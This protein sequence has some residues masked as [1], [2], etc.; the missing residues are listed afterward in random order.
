MVT[1]PSSVSYT[2]G[3]VRFLVRDGTQREE[4]QWKAGLGSSLTACSQGQAS[5]TASNEVVQGVIRLLSELGTDAGGNAKY[6]TN[7]GCGADRKGQALSQGP[8]GVG[9]QGQCQK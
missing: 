4:A 1:V 9:L 3:P 6:G 5:S 8:G 2:A 7:G